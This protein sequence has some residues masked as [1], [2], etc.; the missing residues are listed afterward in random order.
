METDPVRKLNLRLTN[1]TDE[2]LFVVLEPGFYYEDLKSG[3]TLKITV[4]T[5]ASEGLEN[6]FFIEYGKNQITVFFEYKLSA[7]KFYHV[8]VFVNDGALFDYTL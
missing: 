3:A 7:D 6:F 4:D 5:N 8:Q 1:T 2:L